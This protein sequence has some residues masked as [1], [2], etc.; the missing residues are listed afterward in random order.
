MA[1]TA[2]LTADRVPPV[3]P[4][5]VLLLPE[6][7]GRFGPVTRKLLTGWRSPWPCSSRRD[8][9]VVALRHHM[10]PGPRALAGVPRRRAALRGVAAAVPGRRSPCSSSPWCCGGASARSGP[11]RWS[12]WSGRTR[13]PDGR[14]ASP[15]RRPR[16][17]LALG[18][19]CG[20]RP[21][22]PRPRHGSVPTRA[23]VPSQ[24]GPG[25]PAEHLPRRGPAAAT[26]ASP[27]STLRTSMRS[28]CTGP[29]AWR[30]S[31]STS[32]RGST[33]ASRSTAPR[34]PGTSST[35]SAT[36]W[37]STPPTTSPTRP[38]PSS[39]RW[40]T[41]STRS[42]TCGC[43]ATGA[44]STSSG[45]STPTPTRSSATTSCCR[46]T[47]PSR[48]TP[49]RRPPDRPGSTSPARS[50]SCGRTAGPSPT[51]TAASSRR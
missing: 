32:S 44:P 42:P 13:R 26:A 45:T 37:R 39:R 23:D 6:R 7:P 11:S 29:T 24:A 51:T 14:R 16:H 12:G 5:G 17:H 25:P 41:S 47:S 31:P 18:D 34:A 21:R 38:N 8:L 22:G 49:S 4:N 27:S 3:G 19:P 28:C 2:T 1:T 33:G 46:P 9:L 36:R 15:L 43:G 48:S 35:C 30:C 10:G 20:V 50:P 40:P